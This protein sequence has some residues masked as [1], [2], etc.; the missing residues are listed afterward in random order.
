M[1][2]APS[3]PPI[4]LFA[5]LRHEL[6]PVIARLK[7][8][9]QG[10]SHVGRVG[11]HDVVAV[12]SGI[13]AARATAALSHLIQTYE[14]ARLLVIGLCGALVE[15]LAVGDL[16]EPQ[17]LIDGKGGAVQL[18]MGLPR[19]VRDSPDRS[20]GETL[21]TVDTV[22]R[23]PE[24]KR[25]LGEKHRAAAVDMETFAVGK[26]AAERELRCTV[27]RAVSDTVKT[28]LP[29]GIEN[30]VNPDGT[31]NKAAAMKSLAL[32]PWLISGAMKLG[33]NADLAAEKLAQRVEQALVG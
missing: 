33:R 9:P 8:T 5:A 19:V 11:E 29:K 31:T 30:W 22:V 14:P 25:A 1:S 17:W 20:A 15:G 28:T 12:V 4:A 26:L 10:L 16:F 2:D 7:L 6:E 32:K 27:I 23:T 3:N 13:G 18:A 21:I 24:E